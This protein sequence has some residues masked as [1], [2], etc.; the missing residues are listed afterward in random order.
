[1]KNINLYYLAIAL[2]LAGCESSFLENRIVSYEAPGFKVVIDNVIGGKTSIDPKKDY[3]APG[4]Y[5]KISAIPDAGY[6]FVKWGGTLD[7]S[8]NVYILKIDK[9]TW[10]IPVFS[11]DQD[12]PVEITYVISVDEVKNGE[13]I[14]TPKKDRYNFGDYVKLS[15]IPNDG[16][17]FMRW[18]GTINVSESDYILY[19]EKD[20][21]IIPRFS[22]AA[23][24]VPETTYTLRV[25][26]VAGGTAAVVPNKEIY[27]LNETVKIT[28]SPDFGYS[29]A[30]WI[31]TVNN[32]QNP[33]IIKINSDNWIIPKF[34]TNITYNLITNWDP[35]GGALVS[36]SG[37]KTVFSKGEKCS[38]RA[39]PKEGY[40][41][42]GWEG[43][44]ESANS[45]IYITFDRDY[46][47]YPIFSKIPET[48]TYSLSIASTTGG[49]VKRTP[50][51]SSYYANEE[52]LITAVPNSDYIFSAWNSPYTAEEQTFKIVMNSDKTITPVFI[53]RKWSFVVYMAADND[54]E[55]AA[56]NDF[57]EL[58]SINLFNQPVSILVLLDRSPGYD[59][60]NGDWTDTRLFEIKSDPGGDNATIISKRI[61]CSDLGL[62][63]SIPTE[64]DMADPLVLSRLINFTKREYK[65]DNYGLIVWGH[66]T[67]WKGGSS[68]SGNIPEPLKAVAIDDTNSHYYMPL[69]SFGN[70]VSDKGLSVIGFD[71]CFG[72]LLEVAYQLR[73][74][75]AAYLIAS[76][77]LIP[78]NGWNY[79]ELFN[80]FF[81]K[82]GL[83]S[84]DF[85]DSCISQYSSQYSSVSG[86][87]I[88]AIDLTKINDLFTA[89]ENFAQSLAGYITLSN[90][91]TVLNAILNGTSVD[92]YYDTPPSD[93]Y[94]DIYS[95]CQAMGSIFTSINKDSLQNALNAAIPS[96][97]SQKYGTARKNLGVFLIGLQSENVPRANHESG[98][99]KGSSNIEKSDFVENSNYWVPHVTPQINSFLDKLFYYSY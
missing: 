72:A 25:D 88:S 5:I 51:K 93:L 84:A 75:S 67:G 83:S 34:E 96:S 85:R 78:S 50:E 41:F 87:T 71:T 58:E 91:N 63:S 95:F 23:D 45:S 30:G 77:G 26:N 9:D 4:E 15:A 48:V 80:S 66:G 14:V 86:A 31:G 43:D 17:D 19:V 61:D 97:W 40:K 27:Y 55:S 44:I 11:K 35:L 70:A 76:E 73:N 6:S 12:P 24:P 49:I 7:I 20:E 69:K 46:Q 13:I 62:L 89:F 79:G 57:N 53:K 33:L 64:L 68:S 38:L 82:P 2:F 47:V 59:A 16:Y 90:K 54:L 32:T 81:A 8:D 29:F 92:K 94:I 99:I 10:I 3:Y 42:D 65:A 37:N 18:G 74:S 98:Y 39:N 36:S 21:W 52:V 60:T 28:A 22:K 56:I 1:M